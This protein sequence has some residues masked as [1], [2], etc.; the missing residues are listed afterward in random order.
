MAQSTRLRIGSHEHLVEADGKIL[1]R[2]IGLD[3]S[4]ARPGESKYQLGS[5]QRTGLAERTTET[6]VTISTHSS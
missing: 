2:V 4:A 5:K 6:T 1:G 3:T